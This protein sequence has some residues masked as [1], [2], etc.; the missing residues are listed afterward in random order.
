MLVLHTKR[1]IEHE[2]RGDGRI[3]F[4]GRAGRPQR[5]PSQGECQQR[6]D[7]ASQGQQQ[8]VPQSQPMLVERSPLLD[9]P[10]RWEFQLLDPAPHDKVQHDG[11]RDQ[12]RASE[13]SWR[14]ETHLWQSG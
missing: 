11:Q 12:C 2:H 4:A 6:D 10:Q 14:Y 3:V 13:Q 8:Q 9:E 5:R 1:V 7:R